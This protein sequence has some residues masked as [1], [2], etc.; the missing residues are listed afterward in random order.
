MTRSAFVV[1]LGL[2]CLGCSDQLPSTPTPPTTSGP[3][4]PDPQPA[5]AWTVSGTVWVHGPGGVTP[6]R[7][8]AVFGWIEAER[9]GRTTGRVPVGSDGRYIFN[10]PVNTTRVRVN[11]GITG[12]Q[13][14][15]VTREPTG[16]VSADTHIVTDPQQL[17]ANL[18]P[19]LMAQGPTLSGVAYEQTAS[20]RRPLANVWVTLDGLDGL[21][22]LIADTLTD[23]EGR[24]VLCSV[25]HLPGL[26]LLALVDGFELFEFYSGLVGRTT[27]DFEMR[28]KTP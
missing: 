12:Y 9:S 11:R 28:R 7:E 20:G 14:C 13:P 5:N 16:N 18:P 23:S 17:G 27:L 19:E 1:L 2:L 3:Q 21:G 6:A 25:P 15:A 26:S 24:Y 8:G 4:P 22:L 10:I